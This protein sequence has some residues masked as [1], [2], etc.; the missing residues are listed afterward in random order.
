[1]VG[2]KEFPEPLCCGSDDNSFLPNS[3]VGKKERSEDEKGCTKGTT[4]TGSPPS[5]LSGNSFF[6]TGDSGEGIPEGATPSFLPSQHP[7][8]GMVS[9]GGGMVN[10][11]VKVSP[12]PYGEYPDPDLDP[13]GY[14]R[15][16]LPLPK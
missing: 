8:T 12:D 3:P 9:G 16:L 2:K 13:E 4:L 14:D 5:P 10:R 7:E 15:W 6:P 1:M 11:P